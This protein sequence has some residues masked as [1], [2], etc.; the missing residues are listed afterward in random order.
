MLKIRREYR[1]MQ[2]HTLTS[3][4]RWDHIRRGVWLRQLVEED[5]G[6]LSEESLGSFP[7]TGPRGQNSGLDPQAAF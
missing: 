5:K 7:S 6:G 1:G 3:V 4:A 2:E